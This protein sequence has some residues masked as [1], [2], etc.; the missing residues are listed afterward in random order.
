MERK[1]IYEYITDY[2]NSQAV[3]NG[4]IH[5][6]GKDF[7]LPKEK[8]NGLA[9]ADGAMDGISIY[10]MGAPKITEKDM[11]EIAAGIRL[12]AD[13]EYGKADE[14]F[15]S[16]CNR[17]R[18]VNFIDELQ[19]YIVDHAKE[20][21]A[22]NVYRYALHLLLESPDVESIKA[23]MMIFELFN[24]D[25][26]VKS[27]VRTLAL[28][29]EFTLYAVFLMRNWENGQTEI[30]N[31]ARKVSGWGRVHAVHYIEPETEEIREWLL[32]E[33]VN[34][35]VMSAYSG[36]D[37]YE[38]AG[39]EELLEKQSLSYEEIHGI[40]GIIDAML[41]EGPVR[42]ISTVK[43][44]EKVL[45]KV[46]LFAEKNLPLQPEDCEVI[47][48]ISDWQK[49]T[50]R[51]NNS[52]MENLIDAILCDPQSRERIAKAVEK[53]GHIDLAKR[54]G[55]PYKEELYAAM[56]DNFEMLY[57]RCG[58]LM[59]DDRYVEPILDLFRQKIDLKA[60]QTGSGTENGFGEGFEYS[61]KIDFILQQLRDR[62]GVGEDFVE[63]ALNTP[64]IRN[65]NGALR[66]LQRW[67]EKTGQPLQEAEPKLFETIK[68]NRDKEV[69]EG[70]RG[71]MEEL[72]AGA[73]T[74]KD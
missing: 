22:G 45:A 34:N 20:L 29:D 21:D 14:A 51:D 13:G 48:N 11:E 12:A 60:I 67:V 6:L 36:K 47:I 66:V 37:C 63:A 57:S 73:I 31:A 28:S 4:E 43:E 69:D 3:E 27:L 30:L 53:G 5:A 15:A 9:F 16:F 38:K 41:D 49:R 17:I 25:E 74:F 46:L 18:V 32:R 7:H 39:V 42:G 64:V 19:R 61:G 8:T 50:G 59:E 55:L 52:G 54:I 62:V 26:T 65:R 71:R 23:G 1:P 44:P 33:G 2:L 70:V 24:L 35:G 68:I 10:H 58:F 72:I 40:L 56:K